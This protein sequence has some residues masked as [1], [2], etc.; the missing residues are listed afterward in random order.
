MSATAN[1]ADAFAAHA[2]RRPHATAVFSGDRTVSFQALDHLVWRAAAHLARAG[3]RRGDVVALTLGDEFASIVATLA[4]VR[5]GATLVALPANDP[6][7]LRARVAA[8]TRA[9]HL[10][11]DVVADLVTDAD[12]SVAAGLSSIT[13][14]MDRLPELP[15]AADPSDPS[16]RDPAPQAPWLLIVGSGSTGR[17][18]LIA[19]GH[20]TSHARAAMQ[21]TAFG[22]TPTDRI[23]CLSPIDFAITR[24]RYLETLLEG[25][26][27][28]LFDRARD[29]LR[30]VCA[31]HA[32]SVIHGSVVHME[33]L[34]QRAA[35]EGP[36]ALGA[37]RV[38][39]I[40]GSTVADALRAQVLRRISPNLYIAYSMN[41]F[42]IATVIGP[43]RMLRTPGS[44]G[45]PV[46]G[47]EVRVTDPAGRPLPPGE[48]GLIGVRGPGL[49]E[50]YVDAAADSARVFQNGWFVPGDLGL[51][52]ADGELVH[53]GRADHMMILDGINIYPAEIEGVMSRHPAVAD[54]AAV[55]MRSRVHQ[56]IPVCAVALQNGATASE[57][58]LIAHA[59]AELGM[60]MPRRIVVVA[61]IPRTDQGKL[62]RAALT[63]QLAQAL[64][65]PTRDRDG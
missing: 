1:L 52:T 57:A 51:L 34:L 36:P 30:A 48:V 62:M 49:V 35:A 10:V 38:L 28:V 9:R 47:I 32:V 45:W 16:L 22:I 41:E 50:R 15:G 37:L 44:V 42:G 7:P 18:K 63:A 3:V 65:V 61:R 31:R 54:A 25:A 21:R 60:R 20:A 11:T 4:L 17:P 33:R 12:R 23:A 24:Q 29:D 19:L 55:P 64:G 53:R 40:G 2:A 6:P 13:F 27:V 14:D 5:M 26:A 59:R 58:D 8:S 46:P 43:D 56:D 39:R